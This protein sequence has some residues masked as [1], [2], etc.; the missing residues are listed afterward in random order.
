LTLI[1]TALGAMGAGP[2]LE[3]TVRKNLIMPFLALSIVMP[4]LLTGCVESGTEGT[5]ADIKPDSPQAAAVETSPE[6][7]PADLLRNGMLPFEGVLVGG[8]PTA[9]QFAAMKDLGYKTIINI[10][11]PGESGSTNPADVEQLGMAYISM[12]LNGE[13]AVAEESARQLAATMKSAE[14]P[15]VIHCASGNRVGAILG[16][17]AFHV[18]GKSAEESFA[19]AQTA[20]ITRLEPALKEKLGLE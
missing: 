12:P 4:F 11:M 6:V 20:G 9:E 18:D 16:M 2:S 10:R 17:K 3:K 15:I 5:P 7:S 19:I 14:G 13:T 1:S 8:Q